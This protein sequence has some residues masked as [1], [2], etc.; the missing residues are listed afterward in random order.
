LYLSKSA[1]YGLRAALYIARQ[2]EQDRVP[3][4]EISA[5]LDISFHFLTKILQLLTRAGLLSSSTG[6]HGGV[7]LAKPAE[8]ITLRE[9]VEAVEGAE[10]FN[11]CLLGL[12]FCHD[13]HPCPV[14]EDWRP[15]REQI[16]RYFENTTLARLA[17]Q[18]GRH[19]FRLTHVKNKSI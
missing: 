6:P 9:L 8:E 15:L 17:G 4:K 2:A 10:V 18:I 16:N 14:H 19:E 3:I 12:H 5:E 7:R 1:S 13:R 11:D